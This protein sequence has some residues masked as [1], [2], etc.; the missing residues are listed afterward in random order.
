MRGARRTG[1]LIPRRSM[2]IPLDIRA[3]LVMTLSTASTPGVAQ[4]A[5][6]APLKSPAAQSSDV[7][8]TKKSN[9]WA[10]A[11]AG[12]WRPTL[13]A[14]GLV[15][16]AREVTVAAPFRVRIVKADI[17]LGQRVE[18][19]ATLATID[20]PMLADLVT[21]LATDH[22][23]VT[24][25]Q[26]ALEDVRSKFEEKLVTNQD[27]I[28]ARMTV[29]AAIADRDGVWGRLSQALVSLG[30]DLSRADIE[31]TLA[32]GGV[33]KTASSLGVVKAPF[34]GVVM[35]RGALPGV[36]LGAGAALYSIEDVSGIYV[37]VG[38]L[39]GEV[40]QWRNGSAS[41]IVLGNVL[42][43]DN[44]TAVPRLDPDTGLMLL[45]YRGVV[46][47]DHQVDGAWVPATL[48]GDERAVALVPMRALVARQG[49]TW[50]L[51]VDGS[52]AAKP[53]RVTAGPIQGDGR[54]P[55]LTGVAPGQHVLVHNAYEALYRD[56]NALIKFE[57]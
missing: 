40:S 37:D 33:E 25:A 3:A 26:R 4:A 34:T 14:Y 1:A 19:G 43:L 23:R 32:A 31:K 18:Q 5:L 21:R 42:K 6:Q 11:E 20:A 54:V 36:T 17:E 7:S 51:I 46:P 57:D 12:R 50:C 2:M 39:P 22:Q 52:G 38:V 53:V 28:I 8:P 35:K 44:T 55:I 15:S 10:L 16:D 13:S 29:Q 56:L 45:R 24:L 41:A 9:E 49:L 47:G 30:Q 27:V 48:T